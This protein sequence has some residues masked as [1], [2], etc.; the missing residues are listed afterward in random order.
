LPRHRQVHKDDVGTDGSHALH[1]LVPSPGFV[2]HG[3][4]RLSLEQRAQAGTEDDVIV[5]EQDAD[6][7]P[8]AV[9]ETR[10]EHGRAQH[11]CKRRAPCKA[12]QGVT[13]ATS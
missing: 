3:N 5:D 2:D 11:R 7:S 12:Q 4:T 8:G 13:G 1:G 6:G 9:C 10:G